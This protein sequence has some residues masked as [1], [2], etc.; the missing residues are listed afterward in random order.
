MELLLSELPPETYALAV[1]LGLIE[2]ASILP[3]IELLGGTRSTT[4]C[5]ATGTC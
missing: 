5:C 1:E 2:F 3:E 4:T